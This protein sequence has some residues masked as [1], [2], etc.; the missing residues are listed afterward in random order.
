M[1]GALTADDTPDR[2]Q[3][4]RRRIDGAANLRSY[5]V[6]NVLLATLL[7]ACAIVC[8][9]ATSPTVL[10]VDGTRFTLNGKPEFLLGFSYYGGLGASEEFIR[11]DLDDFQKRG[12][13]W[14]RVWGTWDA[15]EHS[16]S[17]FDLEGNPR[18][19]YFEKLKWLV[20]ECDRRGLVVDIS[21]SRQN[22]TEPK[23]TAGQLPNFDA[24]LRAVESLCR[25][26]K[27]QRNWYLDLANERDVRDRRFV[28]AD[29]LKRL[30]DRVREIDPQR[31]VTASFGG[32]DLTTDDLREALMDVGCDFLAR[33]RP[34]HRKSP[35]ETEAQSR[36][37]LK[38]MREMNKSVPLHDQE[39]FRRGYTDWQPTAQ[40]FITDLRGAITG[41]AAGWCF[42]NGGQRGVSDEQP[43]R[44]FDLRA[45]RLWD[46][47]DPEERKF[48]DQAKTSL[49][50]PNR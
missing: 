20:A 10:G 18:K 22:T 24:H 31:L 19:P 5:R 35:A 34:R 48:L 46:Q 32:H 17:A 26:L 49:S 16:I 9:G 41:G 15:F 25:A 47:L 39:P 12:F 45:R 50:R 23:A 40:D 28:P 44:S 36:A 43:R 7:L 29:E 1:I 30:R 11:Q 8:N 37:C 21:L 27:T 38:L 33:H 13:N 42:H 2:N 14:L 6:M 3:Q 4:Q